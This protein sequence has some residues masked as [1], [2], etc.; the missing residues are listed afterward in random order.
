MWHTCLHWSLPRNAPPK[1]R[2]PTLRAFVCLRACW[3]SVSTILLIEICQSVDQ[4]NYYCQFYNHCPV[5][6]LSLYSQHAVGCPN[7]GATGEFPAGPEQRVEGRPIGCNDA[8]ACD[9]MRRGAARTGRHSST[10]MYCGSA[11]GAG[12]A[13]SGGMG[14]ESR[15]V[16]SPT[17]AFGG[18]ASSV[19][20]R[21]S[22]RDLSCD[23]QW[24]PFHHRNLRS[25]PNDFRGCCAWSSR[26]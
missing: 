19:W 4:N 10:P 18:C 13:S 11:A 22:R 8:G 24:G 16:E 17:V 1:S 2:C 26:D 7:L 5:K 25:P 20:V 9:A 6:V 15:G 23:F 12:F 21:E 3:H 14:A